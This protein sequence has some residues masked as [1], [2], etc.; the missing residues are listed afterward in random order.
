MSKGPAFP[1]VRGT[2]T[3]THF[4]LDPSRKLRYAVQLRVRKWLGEQHLGLTKAIK[5]TYILPVASQTSSRR[6]P[7]Y[8]W[9]HITLRSPQLAH[10]Y[11]QYSTRLSHTH[12]NSMSGSLSMPPRAEKMNLCRWMVSM[13]R[14]LAQL[15]GIGRNHT[16]LS[17]Q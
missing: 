13:H 17:I 1:T 6:L 7:I 8:C 14:K 11:P 4:F 9:G 16:N 5:G 10:V 12:P 3:E 15:Y 2:V